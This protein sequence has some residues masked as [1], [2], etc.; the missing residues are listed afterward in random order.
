MA[1]QTNT[2]TSAPELHSF[3]NPITGGILFII[4]CLLVFGLTIIIMTGSYIGVISTILGIIFF[5]L[6]FTDIPPNPRTAGILTFWGSFITPNSPVIVGGKTILLDFFP[7]YI[8]AV[9]I[10]I[11]NVDKDIPMTVTS[12]NNIALDGI[13]S[14]T[15]YPDIDDAV[16]YIQAGGRMEEIFKQLDDIVKKKTRSVAKNMTAL[17]ITQQGEKIDDELMS[18]VKEK[19]DTG[20]FGVKVFKIQSVFDQPKD[21]LEA[22]KGKQKEIYERENESL[23]YETNRIAA[24]KLQEAY[25]AD[26]H[27]A[28]KV[29]TM[30]ECLAETLEQRLIRDNRATTTG[31]KSKGKVIPIVNT[32]SGGG[33]P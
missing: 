8:G 10:D 31:I 3:R 23:E 15:L 25:E 18:H 20:S 26:P 12:S 17:D 13:V 14:I 5:V 11:T 24:K 29:P 2:K 30:Q 27:M 4:I 21:V 9:L 22:M 6:G 16:D 33:T 1:S 7:F 28:G 19:L 32:G